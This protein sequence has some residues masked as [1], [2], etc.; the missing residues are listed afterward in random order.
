[1]KCVDAR[2][3]LGRSRRDPEQPGKGDSDVVLVADCADTGRLQP[4]HGVALFPST[5]TV[6][7]DTVASLMAEATRAVAA[8]GESAKN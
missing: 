3:G 1:M 2:A 8:L 5:A 7:V 4:G 6:H